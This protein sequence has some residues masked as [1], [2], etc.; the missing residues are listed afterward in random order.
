MLAYPCK[1]VL[2]LD[3]VQIVDVACLKGRRA[4]GGCLAV[5]HC[6][7]HS[8]PAGLLRVVKSDAHDLCINFADMLA[9]VHQV[10]REGGG[11]RH[12]EVLRIVC[13]AACVLHMQTFKLCGFDALLWHQSM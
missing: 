3:D 11:L 4:R 9:W 2:C 12:V 6:G 7:T 10:G 1:Y 5:L 8:G 13:A